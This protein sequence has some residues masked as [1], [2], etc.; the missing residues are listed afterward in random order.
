MINFKMVTTSYKRFLQNARCQ[1]KRDR[2]NHEAKNFNHPC[3]Q[4]G[5]TCFYS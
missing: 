5:I 3:N 4:P 2:V 1:Q